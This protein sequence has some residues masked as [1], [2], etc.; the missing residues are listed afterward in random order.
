MVLDVW[1]TKPVAALFGS[2]HHFGWMNLAAVARPAGSFSI[3]SP[4]FALPLGF[5][6]HGRLKGALCTAA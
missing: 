2:E 5:G 6:C 4:L 1:G 3:V